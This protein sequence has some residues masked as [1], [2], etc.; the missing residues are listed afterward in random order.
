MYKIVYTLTLLHPTPPLCDLNAKRKRKK[1]K[2]VTIHCIKIC[3]VVVQ[4]L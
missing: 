1:K 4:V 2:E 3:L